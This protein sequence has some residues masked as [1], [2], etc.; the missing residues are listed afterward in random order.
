[1][2]GSGGS[3][4]AFKTALLLGALSA[5]ILFFGRA[6]G[7]GTGLVIALV[8]ALG[9]NGYAYFNSDKLALRSMRAY[10]VSQVQHPRLYAIVAELASTMRMPMPRLYICLLYTSDAADE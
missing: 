10:P 9:V 1:M 3:A 4:N 6:L 2:H 7:G 8:V 5:L